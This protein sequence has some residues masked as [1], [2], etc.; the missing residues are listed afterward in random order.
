LLH[1]ARHFARHFGWFFSNISRSPAVYSADFSAISLNVLKHILLHFARPSAPS[2]TKIPRLAANIFRLDFSNIFYHPAAYS[3]DFSTISLNVLKCTL[4][5][6]VAFF[7]AFRSISGKIPSRPAAN[8]FRLVFPGNTRSSVAYST[9]CSAIS[10]NVLKCT[11]LH[12]APII[13]NIFCPPAISLNVLKCTLL[14]FA[15]NFSNI[16]Y[17]SAFYSP[18]FSAISLNVL[19]CTL[20]HFVA[21]RQA[22][23]LVFFEHFLSSG[24][25]FRRLL[26]DFVE[27]SEA[28][29][30]AFRQAFGP[31][32]GKKSSAL[33]W[34]IPL[35]FPRFH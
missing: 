7:L 17:P 15:P 31:I 33:R 32:S 6:F 1:F 35:T 5:H 30:A 13:S 8:I 9:D 34:L 25:L 3:A 12:F 16:F 20:L 10:L 29:F 18:D 24:D 28:Y 23:R 11:L 4:L 2:R 22:F 21:F 14:H 26:G 27:C 19:K